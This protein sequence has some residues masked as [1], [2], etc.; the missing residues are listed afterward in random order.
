MADAEPYKI[1]LT[2]LAKA[3]A[4]LHGG[5]SALEDKIRSEIGKHLDA[6]NEDLDDDGEPLT[7]DDI[8]MFT[9]TL[10]GEM[11]EMGS[12]SFIV[13]P[14]GPGVIR[15][16]SASFVEM[17]TPVKHGP[18]AGKRVVFPVPDSEGRDD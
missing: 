16:D 17:P 12:S 8:L 2:P 18:F 1:E 13:R 14:H 3:V 9:V 11:G 5:V 7:V 15:A 10:D 4:A 6:E